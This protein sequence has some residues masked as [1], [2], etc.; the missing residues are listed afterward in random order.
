ML[1]NHK[2]KNCRT[3]LAR[4]FTLIE[5]IAVV[6]IIGVMAT[7]LLPS[8]ETAMQ[9]SCDTKLITT[10]TMIDGAGRIYKLE[11]GQFPE[12]IA[13]LVEG[14]YLPAKDYTMISY[15]KTTGVAS[16]TGSNGKQLSSG[17]K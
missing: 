11:H 1:E 14:N 7:A 8:L 2:H 4:G 16:G 9:K 5:I 12:S 13:I 10:L 15:D 3:K 6:A 17:Q